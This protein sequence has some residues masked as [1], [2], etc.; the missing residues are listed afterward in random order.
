MVSVAR[1][2]IVCVC[3]I[4]NTVA[5]AIFYSLNSFCLSDISLVV[6]I[7]RNGLD[8]LEHRYASALIS[9]NYIY[10]TG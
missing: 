4:C 5:R 1:T 6:N 9:T 2:T 10:I 7:L 8:H 3:I